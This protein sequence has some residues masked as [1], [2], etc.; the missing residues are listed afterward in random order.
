MT[1]ELRSSEHPDETSSS[2]RSRLES[3]PLSEV[4]DALR[5]I[6]DRAGGWST[7]RR[8]FNS[9][10]EFSADFVDGKEA[11]SR[12]A[13]LAIGA[14]AALVE[15]ARDTG[16]E[17]D[18]VG[19]LALGADQFADGVAVYLRDDAEW[20]VIRKEPKGW[21]TNKLVEGADIEGKRVLLVDDVV[22]TG[23]SIQQAYRNV[24]DAGGE[25]AMA[26]TLVD[27]SDIATAFPGGRSA[28][29]APSYVWSPGI[30]PLGG[31]RQAATA[32]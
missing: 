14:G 21:G 20:F 29:S 17:F 32:G 19:G 1:R 31:P 9:S 7:F 6:V 25:V 28:V 26:V 16:V 15:L 18:A 8:G 13:D 4:R 27:R 24:C 22:S 30:E 3:L 5:V 12:G 23:G 10:G 2:S 11:L